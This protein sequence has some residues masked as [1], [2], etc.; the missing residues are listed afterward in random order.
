M[1]S[2]FAQALLVALIAGVASALMSGLVVR[3][4]SPALLLTMLAPAPLMI[5]GFGW[6]PLVAALGGI[7][8]A[9]M[10]QMVNST[11]AAV[12]LCG[13]VALPAYGVS[14]L[15]LNRFAM[16]SQ[17]PQRDGKEMGGIGVL[18]VIFLTLAAV[19]AAMWI[20]PDFEALSR[21]MR[22]MIEFSMRE[23]MG[24]DAG[25]PPPRPE[26]MARLYA[27]LAR[28]LLPMSVLVTL[29][30]LVLSATLAAQVAERAGLMAYPR[31]DFRRFAVPGGG[32]ILIGLAF[33]V[34]TRPGYLGALGD[35]V[36]IGML[37]L[38]LLQGLAV[39][40]VRTLNVGGRG[41]IL[42]LVWASLIVFGFPAF[43]FMLVGLADHLFAF[44]R[45]HL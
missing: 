32:L 16:L 6:H 33:L 18:L 26:A 31:P 9:L 37:F 20:E 7:V 44:R 30:T 17:R 1:K 42:F 3:S 41:I 22:E 8:A 13:M 12:M 19:L 40:H 39:I 14:A 35:G 4:S 27:F 23:M 2:P 45:N 10:A 28:I 24:F 15:A 38:F 34:A 29:T 11:Q 25:L 36:F 5:A 43:L 21:R